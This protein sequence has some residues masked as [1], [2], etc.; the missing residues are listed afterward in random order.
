MEVIP[1]DDGLKSSLYAFTCTHNE[2][3][4]TRL[5]AKHLIFICGCL[6]KHIAREKTKL[7][8]KRTITATL[9]ELSENGSSGNI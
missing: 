9:V 8:P 7:W 4:T 3:L 2:F 5:I 1:P 6:H